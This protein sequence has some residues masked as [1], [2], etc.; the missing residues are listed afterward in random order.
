MDGGIIKQL[1][2]SPP[3][4]LFPAPHHCANQVPFVCAC[5]EHGGEETSLQSPESL[6]HGNDIT[7][8]VMGKVLTKT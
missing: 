5:K 4:N 2:L 7:G 6:L 1:R 3:A 8:K